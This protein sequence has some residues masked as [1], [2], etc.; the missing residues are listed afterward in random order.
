M[1]YSV[2]MEQRPQHLLLVQTLM[3]L[4]NGLRGCQRFV[5]NNTE[6]GEQN[7]H[8]RTNSSMPTGAK[9]PLKCFLCLQIIAQALDVSAREV[10]RHHIE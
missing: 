10:Q 7:R 1:A 2:N 3:N 6:G 5:A 4:Q 8:H 9:L